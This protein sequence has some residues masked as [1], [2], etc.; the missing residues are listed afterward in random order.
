MLLAVKA[1]P[2]RREVRLNRTLWLPIEAVTW[3]DWA[4]PGA[5]ALIRARP[6]ASVTALVALS[7]AA[8]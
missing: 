4:V 8:P 6:W 1:G 7:E 3:M 2:A 5:V